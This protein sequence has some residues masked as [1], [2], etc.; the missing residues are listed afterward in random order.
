MGGVPTIKHRRPTIRANR[1]EK[2]GLLFRWAKTQLAG[3][4]VHSFAARE[5][6]ITVPFVRT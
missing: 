4:E 2:Y 1:G 3:R 6:E 5:L